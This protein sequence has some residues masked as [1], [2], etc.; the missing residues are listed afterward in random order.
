MIKK[1]F[2]N[3]EI[4]ILLNSYYFSVLYYNS[5]IWLSPFLHTGPKQQLLSASS[6]AIRSC[7]KNPTRYISFENL[8][9]QFKKSTPDQIA[10]YKISLLLFKVFNNIVQ[11]KDW[12]DF[13]NQIICTGRQT[14]FDLHKASNYKIENNILCNKLTCV[15][16]LI[17][18]DFFNLNFPTYK[19][20]M[21]NIFL[22]NER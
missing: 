10:L 7:L 11:G 1:Y 19:Y 3:D 14:T 4:K 8:H 18:L 9:K 20:K 5:E 12:I 22:H 6:N 15:T 13:N 16:R 2:T 17:Q 21:K